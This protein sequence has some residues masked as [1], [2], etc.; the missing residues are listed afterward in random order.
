[1][2]RLTAVLIAGSVIT[3]VLS[4][5][6][7]FAQPSQHANFDIEIDPIAYTMNGFSVHGGY[8]IDRWR[9][10]LG[11]FGL[12]HPDWL[13]GN[14]DFTSSFIGAGWKLDRYFNDY[15]DGWFAG[16]EGGV[17]Q[18]EVTHRDIDTEHNR[19]HY[20]VGVRGGYRWNTGLGKLYI[21][22]WLGLGVT[23]NAEDITVNGDVYE[24]SV[25]QPFPTVHLGWIF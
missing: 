10:D 12:E 14:D 2:K 21:V 6:P 3:V 22:P 25:F 20:S 19:L 13:H 24:N 1:M 15:A 17:M 5:S 9:I 11:V 8:H 4:N 18:L 23:L 7:A 16:L